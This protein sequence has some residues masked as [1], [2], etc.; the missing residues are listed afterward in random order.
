MSISRRIRPSRPTASARSG[1][2]RGGGGLLGRTVAS[3]DPTP[4][5]LRADAPVKSGTG[6][7]CQ[8]I[9]AHAPEPFLEE[10]WPTTGLHEMYPH[11]FL[12]VSREWED[13]LKAG[14]DEHVA[15]HTLGWQVTWGAVSQVVGELAAAPGTPQP[16]EDA[17][18]ADLWHR[19]RAALPADLR[20]AGAAPSDEAQTARWG[21]EPRTSLFR[22]L[23]LGTKARDQRGWHTTTSELDRQDGKDEFRHVAGDTRIGDVSSEALIGE[24]RATA[25][26]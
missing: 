7:T 22:Q 24:I 21:F 15:D 17:A 25:G 4:P 9:P 18:R 13:R 16:T 20:P 2:S 26:G 6:W 19:F 11:V 12:D 10:W 8:A 3:I 1:E 5:L 14:E 23:F